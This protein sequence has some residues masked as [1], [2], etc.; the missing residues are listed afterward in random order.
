VS[1]S[2]GLL[3]IL[4]PDPNAPRDIRLIGRY[5]LGVEWQDG[6]SSIF[7]FDLLR[8]ACPCPPCREATAASVASSEAQGWPMEIKREGTGVRIRWQDDHVSTF[9]GRDLRERC[10]CASC[11]TGSR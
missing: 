3:P 7:P 1:A 2:K 5:A 11:T 6:H 8:E 4:G 10:R 9:G